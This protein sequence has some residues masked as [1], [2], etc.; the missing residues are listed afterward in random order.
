MG[1]SG[2]FGGLLAHK[3]DKRRVQSAARYS[4]WIAQGFI[5]APPRVEKTEGLMMLLEDLLIFGEGIE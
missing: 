5:P 3:R 1:K 2:K 4:D